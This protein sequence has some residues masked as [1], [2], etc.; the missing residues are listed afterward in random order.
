M[1]KIRVGLVGVG[2]CASSLI[3][4]IS[5]AQNGI[6][7][8]GLSHPKLSGY[9]VEDLSIVAAFDVA[10]DKVGRDLAQAATASTNLTT[11]YHEVPPQD[12]VVRAGVLGDGISPHM[13][14][15]IPIHA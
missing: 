11:V 6:L 5:A 9:G 13:E 3:Q 4:C 14:P 10:Q 2:N 1:R 8:E 12:V 15:F 7:S